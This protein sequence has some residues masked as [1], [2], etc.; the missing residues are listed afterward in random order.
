MSFA[1]LTAGSPGNDTHT[2][3][4]HRTGRAASQSWVTLTGLH[5]IGF[6]LVIR[7]EVENFYS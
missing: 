7:G 2:L 4:N 5:S 6:E 1:V 3:A